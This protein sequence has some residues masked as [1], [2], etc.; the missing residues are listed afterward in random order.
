MACVVD[1]SSNL[2][3]ALNLI[4][5][6]L[7]QHTS[8]NGILEVGIVWFQLPSLLQGFLNAGLPCNCLLSIIF[9]LQ[10]VIID[11]ILG[12]YPGILLIQ[13]HPLPDQV[14]DLLIIS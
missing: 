14:V 13:S 5:G 4:Q 7:Y 6:D 12:C 10:V 11:W 8:V 1:P 3:P 2:L 9:Q